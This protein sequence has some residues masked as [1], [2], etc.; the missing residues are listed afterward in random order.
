MT[1]QSE[2]MA[3]AK[4]PNLEYNLKDLTCLMEKQALGSPHGAQPKKKSK[5]QQAHR[6]VKLSCR[7]P[8]PP[9]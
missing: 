1:T 9:S 4:D 7:Q 6:P 5:N 8:S 3:M 2:T